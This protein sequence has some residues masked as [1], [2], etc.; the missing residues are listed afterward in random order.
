MTSA[1][2]IIP[3]ADT[4]APATESS[5]RTTLAWLS[6]HSAALLDQVLI[7]GAN[8]VT[9]VCTARALH[10]SSAAFGEFSLVYAALLFVNIVQST[11]ITQPHNV[12]GTTR[13]GEPYRRFTTTTAVGQLLL[14]GVLALGR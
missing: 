12:L 10:P 7:S 3:I 2:Q 13:K 14:S 6:S 11:L 1:T 9:M 5:G 8:F 4:T